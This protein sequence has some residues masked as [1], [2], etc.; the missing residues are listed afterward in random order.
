MNRIKE[1]YSLILEALVP[2]FVTRGNV[3]Q[4]ATGTR[5][6]TTSRRACCR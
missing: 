3:T 6:I 4:S 2:F 5:T 1:R